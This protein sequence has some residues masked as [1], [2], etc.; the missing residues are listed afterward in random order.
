MDPTLLQGIFNSPASRFRMGYGGGR[1]DGGSMGGM[2]GGGMG[3]GKP[4]M[5]PPGNPMGPQGPQMSPGAGFMPPGNPM[6]PGASIGAAPGGAQGG[7]MTQAPFSPRAPISDPNANYMM[8]QL[9]AGAQQPQTPNM[10][11]GTP[12]NNTPA[13]N[14]QNMPAFLAQLKAGADAQNPYGFPGAM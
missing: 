1:P 6:G 9:Q 11:P 10:Q 7:P 13:T 3:G 5:M 8:S 2:G 4:P 12:I 14:M